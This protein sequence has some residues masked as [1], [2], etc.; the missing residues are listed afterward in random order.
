[1]VDFNDLEKEK[2]VIDWEYLTWIKSKG[3]AYCGKKAEPHHL[4]AVGMGHSR[5]E[6]QKG[7]DYSAIPLCRHHHNLMHNMGVKEFESK[8]K[9]GQCVWRIAWKLLEEWHGR[10][11]A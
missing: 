5:G 6:S 8:D 2:S 11:N 9:S 10:D 1:M 7:S 4:V 3:C